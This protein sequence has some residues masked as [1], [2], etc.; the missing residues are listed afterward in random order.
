MQERFQ[1]FIHHADVVVPFKLVLHIHE[2]FVEGIKPSRQQFAN[3]K[4]DGRR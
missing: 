3:V 1:N 2:I 4:A